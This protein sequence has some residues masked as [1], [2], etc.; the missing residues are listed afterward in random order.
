VSQPKICV[1]GSSNVDLVAKT[2]RLPRLGET[3]LGREFYMGF[4]GKGANQAVMAAKLGARVTMV[5]K[6]GTGYLGEMTLKNFRR[7]GV[8]TRFI[9]FD[10][11]HSTGV[12]HILVDDSGA[13]LLVYI[14][15]ANHRL[16]PQDILKA[17]K[18]IESADVLISQLEIPLQTVLEAFRI[19][20]QAGVTTILNPAPGRELPAE[21]IRACDVIAP[22][23]TETELITG[24]PVGSLEE[25]EAAAR[26]ILETGARTV[27]LTLGERGSLLIEQGGVRR[28]AAK[29]TAAVDTTGAG[30]AFIGSLAY[31]LAG[32]EEM[33]EAVR[34][35]GEIAAISVTRLGTQASFPRAEEIRHLMSGRGKRS[36]KAPRSGD[37]K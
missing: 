23:E 15:G 4:G 2:P 5:A 7:M 24:M 30:D 34:R 3:L 32:G 33:S 9:S 26:K 21:L 20:A 28:F 19:A 29:K 35:A 22:N 36:A 14:P 18:V 37:P 13:N 12:A 25:L 31:F 1:V 8:D 6:L 17:R 11:E 16:L 10:E 27:V